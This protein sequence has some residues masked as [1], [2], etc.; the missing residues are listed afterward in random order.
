MKNKAFIGA[1]LTLGIGLGTLGVSTYEKETTGDFNG[2]Y[3]VTKEKK[4]YNLEKDNDT[5]EHFEDNYE[6]ISFEEFIGEDIKHFDNKEIE[7]LKQFYETAAENELK[8]A[9][10]WDD[11]Q[12]T[13]ENIAESKGIQL[14]GYDEIENGKE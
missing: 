9:K 10:A 14:E 12:K 7:K 2:V 6:S 11:F 1:I 13:L 4:I 3:N 5:E 8:A